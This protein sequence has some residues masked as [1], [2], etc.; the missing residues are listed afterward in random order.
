VAGAV[1]PVSHGLLPFDS[2]HRAFADTPRSSL[3][4]SLSLSSLNNREERHSL[5]G[6]PFSPAP[7]QKSSAT[8]AARGQSTVSKFVSSVCTISDT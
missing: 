7:V 1:L 6:Y 4:I 2:V 5:R 3:T 8:A